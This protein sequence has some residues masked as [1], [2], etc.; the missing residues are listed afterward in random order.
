MQRT[1]RF[2]HELLA[3]EQQSSRGGSS[4][5]A[6]FGRDLQRGPQ[7]EDRRRSW[8]KRIASGLFPHGDVGIYPA[9][10]AVGQKMKLAQKV[11][12]AEAGENRSCR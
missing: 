8:N 2:G 3:S 6:E 1:V 5:S 7:D 10:F 9:V 4:A 11:A 12:A